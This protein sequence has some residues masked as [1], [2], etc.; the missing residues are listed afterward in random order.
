MAHNL[1]LEQKS[2]ITKLASNQLLDGTC[3]QKPE[4]PSRRSNPNQRT[5]LY[6]IDNAVHLALLLLLGI[7]QNGNVLRHLANSQRRVRHALLAQRLL[8]A[9]K[10]C[11]EF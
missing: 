4:P 9:L 6:I 3:A 7:G 2:S 8:A 1:E 10:N 5:F 11:F